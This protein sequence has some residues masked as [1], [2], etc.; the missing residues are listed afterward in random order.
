MSVKNEV[1]LKNKLVTLDCNVFLL[2]LVGNLDKKHISLFKRTQIFTEEDFEILSLLIKGSQLMISPN[3]A[4]EASNLLESYTFD[5]EKTGLIALQNA[6]QLIPE[7]YESS[8]RL[9][10]HETFFKYGLSDASIANLCQAGAVAITVDFPLY[11]FLSSKN[12]KVI[13]FNHIR[14]AYL[15]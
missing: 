5:K 10:N 9:S 3:V 4:T 1:P 2:Y 11:G 12:L 6:C 15:L 13:N 7:M 14:G 8:K